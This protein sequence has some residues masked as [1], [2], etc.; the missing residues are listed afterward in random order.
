MSD[1]FARTRLTPTQ[2]RTV[3]DRRLDDAECLRKTGDNARAN[4]VFYLGGLVVDCL[5]KAALLERHPEVESPLEVEHLSAGGRHVR[6]LI[7]RSHALDEM[8]QYLPDLVERPD[9]LDAREGTRRLPKLRNLCA[10]WSIFARYSP[11][12]ETMAHASQFLDAVR[13]L[14]AWLK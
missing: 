12:S 14:K 6:N 10:T 2:A 11:R 13:E 1:I 9:R 8:L 7:F 4:G 3:A 5:L